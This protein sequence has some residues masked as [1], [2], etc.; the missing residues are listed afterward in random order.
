MKEFPKEKNHFTPPF[1]NNTSSA[2][3]CQEK[4]LVNKVI[5]A[6]MNKFTLFSHCICFKSRKRDNPGRTFERKPRGKITH[7]SK[8]S[9]FRLFELLAKIDNKLDFQP[10]FVTLTY[11]HG[12]QNSKK[13]TKSQLHNFLTQLRNFDP[14]VQF[15]WRAELQSR[16][17]PHYHL[18]IFPGPVKQT[19]YKDYYQV[20]ISEI[21]HSIA[22][23][24]S[25]KHK[26]YGCK[27]VVIKNYRE[28]CSYM[29][30]YVAKQEID[31]TEIIEGKH[32]GCSKDL[33]IKAYK[34]WHCWD[35]EAKIIIERI[36]IWLMNHGKEKYADPDYLNIYN[37]TT[38]FIDLKDTEILDFKYFAYDSLSPL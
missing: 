38:V 18:I 7:F 5:Q 2:K 15:I 25:Y 34:R 10:L 37:D 19:F 30:K 3:F 17:A 26:E 33:P 32:W 6:N 1:D 22:D 21:W 36:R 24:K 31:N 20:R 16:G 9:R 13:S 27:M 28:A 4:T 12:H 29:S 14:D 11:H 23:P 35:E 8:M